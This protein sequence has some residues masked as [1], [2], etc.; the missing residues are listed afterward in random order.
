MALYFSVMSA[1]IY[2][3]T[4]SYMQTDLNQIT[5]QIFVLCD[6]FFSELI[7]CYLSVR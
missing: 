6:F 3:S 4:A 5:S 1:T 7:W 2:Y